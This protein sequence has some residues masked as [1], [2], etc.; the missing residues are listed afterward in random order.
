MTG[1]GAI[2]GF[3]TA[4]PRLTVAAARGEEALYEHASEASEG[5][6]PP[7]ARQLLRHVEEAAAAA[8][9]WDEVTRL[10]VGIG[11]GSYTGAR[12]GVASARG[13]AQALGMG[14][15]GVVSLEALARGAGRAAGAGRLVASVIDARRGQVFA[16]LYESGKPLWEPFVAAPEELAERLRELKGEVICGG[17]GSIR[18]RG[19]LEDAGA[20]VL[21][22]GDEGHLISARDVCAIAAGREPSAPGE[23]EPIYLRPP[24]A[25]IWREEQRRQPNGK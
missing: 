15:V 9:G 2:V 4:T 7:H 17:D 5:R 12:I 11:P 6:R 13:L 18:F 16:A 8:G 20:R 10:A 21:A 22:D 3:D 19:Q 24:D 14:L 25:E 1:Q 23:I